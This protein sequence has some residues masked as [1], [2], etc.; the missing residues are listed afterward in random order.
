MS[1]HINQ[2]QSSASCTAVTT[3]TKLLG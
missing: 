2:I 1:K 3:M